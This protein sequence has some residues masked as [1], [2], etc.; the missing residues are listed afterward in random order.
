MAEYDMTQYMNFASWVGSQG[1]G[2]LHYLSSKEKSRAR[3]EYNTWL[4]GLEAAPAEETVTTPTEEVGPG[5]P[6]TPT[7]T[8][9]QQL[10]NR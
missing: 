6:T 9:T 10:K 7:V 1:L 8:P 3:V 5:L 4:A 2:N